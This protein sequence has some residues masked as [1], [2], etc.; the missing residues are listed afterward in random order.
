VYKYFMQFRYKDKS[1]AAHSAVAYFLSAA[2]RTMLMWL[3]EAQGN[4]LDG[5]ELHSWWYGIMEQ[6]AG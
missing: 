3:K 4:R 6:I 1:V 2:H 5:N